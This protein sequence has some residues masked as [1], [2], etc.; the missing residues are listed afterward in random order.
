MQL[1]RGISF[2]IEGKGV[3]FKGSKLGRNYSLMNLEQRII[4]RKEIKK[5]EP[6]VQQTYKAPIITEE[7]QIRKPKQFKLR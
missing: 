2:M 7:E 1:G 4:A 6:K 5:V 3:T